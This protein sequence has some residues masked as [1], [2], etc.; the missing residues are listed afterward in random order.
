MA[1]PGP[2]VPNYTLQQADIFGGMQKGFTLGE[3]FRQQRNQAAVQD[4]MQSS[5]LS[6]PEGQTQAAQKVSAYNPQLGMQMMGQVRAS[7]E[8]AETQKYHQL[9]AQ[10][11]IDKLQEQKVKDA[12]TDTTSRLDYMASGGR[13]AIEAYEDSYDEYMKNNP[14]ANDKDARVFANEHARNQY[15]IF[16]QGMSKQVDSQGNP[17]FNE[18]QIAAVPENF[19]YEQAKGLLSYSTKAQDEHGKAVKER[20]QAAEAEHKAGVEQ[21]RVDIAERKQEAL[22]AKQ[23]AAENP[24]P[25]DWSKTGQDFLNSLP[26]QDRNIVRLVGDYEKNPASLSRTGGYREKITNAAAQYRQGYDETIYHS[27]QKLRD[28]FFAGPEARNVTSLNTAIGHMGRLSQDVDALGNG[29]V[30]AWNSMVNWLRTQGGHPEVT[31]FE[32][33]R[34]AVAEELMKSFRGGTGASTHEA[35]A[36]A[37]RFKAANSPKQLKDSIKEGAELLQS[38]IEALNDQWNRGMETEG[39]FPNLLSKH[40]RA[41]MDTLEGKKPEATAAPGKPAE[42]PTGKPGRT[43]V[44]TGT[45][46]GKKVTQYSDGSIEYAN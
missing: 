32:T 35:E 11:R 10:E 15:N 19:D 33:A 12:H 31:N 7:Q 14:G 39:G 3:A 2:D 6:T 4:V 40:S 9:L 43:V 29:N 23:A 24:L 20:R 34:I 22:E 46:D 36:W 38:R 27:R 44:R 26:P 42:A 30:P 13:I 37:T 5:D 17:L 8:F 21:K 25:G 18:K 45:F 28:A 41:T 1:L 16:R